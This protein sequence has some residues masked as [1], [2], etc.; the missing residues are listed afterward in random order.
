ME[1]EIFTGADGF[2]VRLPGKPVVL[3][4]FRQ[5]EGWGSAREELPAQVRKIGFG[6][7]PVELQEEI[8]AFA[9]RAE[10]I[11]GPVWGSPN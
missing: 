2:F 7:L 10:A 5:G 4:W 8:L 1:I 3:R 9:A 11:G 6:E